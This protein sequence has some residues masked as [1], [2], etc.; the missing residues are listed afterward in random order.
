MKAEGKVQAHGYEFDIG[1]SFASEQRKYV[2]RVAE[3]LNYRGV[4]VYYD[5]YDQANLW[6]RD[7]GEYFREVFQDKCHYCIVFASKEYATKM[8]PTFELENALKKTTESHKDY[9]L[10]VRFDQTIIRVSPTPWAT[11]TRTAAHQF[12]LVDWP[13]RGSVLVRYPRAL[14]SPFFAQASN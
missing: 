6:G 2:E 13:H 3:E 10:P 1:L 9:I 12:R 14:N 4:R 8:W 7:L 5:A 11:S